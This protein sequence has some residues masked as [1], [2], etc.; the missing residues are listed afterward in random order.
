MRTIA[1]LSRQELLDADQ[2]LSKLSQ[3]TFLDA[4]N[5][6]TAKMGKVGFI[7]MKAREISSGDEFYI[8]MVYAFNE[9]DNRR[10]LWD[11]LCMFKRVISTTWV[12]CG[13]F[14]TVLSPLERLGGYTSEQ[15]MED[16]QNCID[17][18]ELIDSPAIGS[19]FTWNN[20]QEPSSRIYSRLD[21]VLISEN[22]QV[23]RKSFEYFHMWS[24]S[25][26]FHECVKRV[27]DQHWYG[28]KMFILVKKVK[29]LKQ[30][31]KLLNIAQFDD[32]ENNTVRAWQHLEYIQ[33]KLRSDP[34]NADLIQQENDAAKCYRELNDVSCAF[35]FQKSKVTWVDKGDN[36]TKYFHSVLKSRQARNKVVKIADQNGVACESTDQIQQAFLDFYIQLLGTAKD[37]S[38]VSVSVVQQGIVCSPAHAE[39]LLAP[40][41]NDE[42]KKMKLSHLMFADDL[43]L[44]SKGDAASIMVLLRVFTT[45]SQASGLHMN[46]SKTNAY[47]NGVQG[48]IKQEILQVSSFMEG[49]LPFSYLGV[50]ITAGRLKKKDCQVLIEKLVSKIRGFGARHLSYAGRLVLVNSVLNSL[51]T[52]WANIFIIPKGVLQ[53]VD[54]I[55]RNYLWDGKVDYIRVPLV[56]WE[57]LC[58]PKNEGGLGIRDSYAWNIAAIGKLVWWVFSKPD[59]LW[60]RWVH[61]VYM[62]GA[63]W[64]DYNPTYDVRWSWK[65]IVKVRDKLLGSY[66]A[67]LW[68]GESRGYTVRSSYEVMRRKFQR[69]D[70]HKQIWNGCDTLCLVCGNADESHCHLFQDCE[71]SLRILA[72]I[73]RLC[74][75]QLPARNV[76][77]WVYTRQFTKLQKGV[78]GSAFLAAHYAIWMQRNKVRVDSCLMKPEMVIAQVQK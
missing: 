25:E 26:Q 68:Q 34:L 24:Q 15:E 67:E 64:S 1:R 70:W 56:G 73:A 71:Y 63:A 21:R 65:A 57:K 10:I 44:F 76:R 66:S 41:T 33:G 18:C 32:I 49:Q 77:A 59:S 69:V 13:D 30:P 9:V 38:L 23:K 36:N 19:L 75:I 31:L 54:A 17:E 51:Y 53:Q 43:L 55:C 28:T 72:G 40:V 6:A 7:Q 45:F 29:S 50:L 27:W 78:L 46:N 48:S 62:K 60:I 20:K 22:T 58:A 11:R 8:T 37:T 74:N 14:N 4:L 52:Y 3:Y 39:M 47:F 2:N 12:V 35:L 42:I 61:H 16:F 5:N